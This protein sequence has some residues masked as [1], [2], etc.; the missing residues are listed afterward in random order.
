M[1]EEEKVLEQINQNYWLNGTA[2]IKEGDLFAGVE[3]AEMLSNITNVSDERE[4]FKCI[5]NYQGTFKYKNF[6]FANHSVYGCFVYIAKN[7]KVKQFEHIS[8]SSMEHFLDWIREIEE[9]N[10]KT[11][12]VEEFYKTY[13]KI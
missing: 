7:G 10:N 1:E 9:V 2:E 11:K 6:Y 8:F 12:T 13:F 5:E 4:L 3:N